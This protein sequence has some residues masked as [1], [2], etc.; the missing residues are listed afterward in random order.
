MLQLTLIRHAK[1]SWNDALLNDYKRPL[2]QRGLDNATLMGR[3]LKERGI[4]FDLMVSSPALRAATT[5]ELLASE[6]GYPTESIDFDKK[7]YGAEVNTL[8][9]VV[10]AFPDNKARIALVAHNPGLTDFCNYLCSAGIS[11][12]PTCAI[13]GIE[14]SVDDWSA[15]YRDTGTLDLYEYP[16][17]HTD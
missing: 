10:Q 17:K 9:E 12:L 4:Q 3:I 7:L 6:L 15:V 16:R 5:A 8:L 11:N 2:N 14:F 1:S 13:A